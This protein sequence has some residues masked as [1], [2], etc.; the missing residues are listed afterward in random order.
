MGSF[1]SSFL[2]EPLIGIGIIA[3]IISS[4]V[5][6]NNGETNYSKWLAIAAIVLTIIL[7]S[8]KI[9]FSLA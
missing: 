4:I 3:L 9:F 5:K 6:E 1:F 8:L 7:I 2:V